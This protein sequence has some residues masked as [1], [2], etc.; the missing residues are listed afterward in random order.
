MQP[1]PGYILLAGAILSGLAALF[2]AKA[3]GPAIATQLGF[4]AQQVIARAGGGRAVTA[5]FTTRQG[6]PT[7]HPVLRG[8]HKLDDATRA[9]VARA[10]AAVPGVGAVSWADGAHFHTP[11]AP[12]PRPLHCQKDVE[13][14]LTARTIRFDESS[15]AIDR[16][17]RE[18][19]D[20]VAQALRPCLGGVIAIIGHTDSV[21]SESSN[22][23]L[24]QRRAEAVQRAL[25]ERGIPGDGLRASGVG[26]RFPISGLEP[27]D[28]A[29]RRIEFSVL[30]T[31]P[32]K[33]TPIDTP[34]AR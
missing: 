4:Q 26:S 21:G 1:R 14:L 18:L 27:D 20:E 15:A 5:D 34:G 2:A 3:G 7:R 30:E 17:S 23:A 22:L 25:I 24:S 31:V 13:A 29:N 10:V 12:P 32:L 28:P 6:W 19:I 8:G 9:R 16:S 11:S 33:P